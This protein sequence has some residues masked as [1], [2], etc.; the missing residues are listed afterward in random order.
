MTYVR[1]YRMTA[2]EGQGAALRAALQALLAKVAPLDGCLRLEL[3]HD[4]DNADAY[5]LLEHWASAQAHK[6]GGKALG[7]DAFAPVMAVLSAPPEAASLN[8]LD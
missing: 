8:S 4:A 7:K 6:D 2:R 5:V 1:Y 3:L